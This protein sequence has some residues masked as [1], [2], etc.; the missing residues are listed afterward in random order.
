MP[1]LLLVTV[2]VAPFVSSMGAVGPA[3][4]LM[5]LLVIL[6]ALA[7]LLGAIGV[8]GVVSHFVSR[9][10]RE[11]SI[12]LALGLKPSTMIAQ[13]VTR[14]GTLVAIGAGIGVV[15]ALGMMQVLMTFLYQVK[16]ADSAS[17][18]GAT[19]TLLTAGMIAAFIPALRASRVD[20]AKVLREQ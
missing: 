11:W 19:A 12:R 20:P 3:L 2:G 16:P 13:I 10:R 6:G 8:Y 4:Q 1:A 17:L 14:G 7:L 5:A 15:A 9:R 18:L